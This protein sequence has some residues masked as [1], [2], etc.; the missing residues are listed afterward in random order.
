MKQTR[1]LLVAVLLVATAT[2]YAQVAINTD[3]STP[4]P[5]AM[6]EV[7]STSA[8]FLLP[9][10]TEA[11]RNAI[12]NP[13][14]GLIVYCSDCGELQIYIDNSWR[15]IL[16]GLPA[17]NVP[18]V[19][20]SITGKV[21]MDRNLGATQVATSST[22]AAAYGD[23][24]QWGRLADGHE[25]RLSSNTTVLSEGDEP[26]HGDFIV[27]ADFPRDWRDPQNTSLWVGVTGTN[28]PCPIGFRIPTQTEWEDER[29]SWATDDADGAFGSPLK[30][31]LSG[32]RGNSNG[33]V[34]GEALFG[35]YWTTYVEFEK[36]L[37]F[38]YDNSSGSPGFY[39]GYRA[40]GLSVRCI[41]D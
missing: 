25:S 10:M 3:G 22:D 28:N 29:Q 1:M 9:R 14:D 38:T 30:L 41:K 26:G 12:A 20:N 34:G 19:T 33:V 35:Y 32:Y 6:L 24:Y 11:Q 5:S 15:N 17:T 39:N 16:G 40:Y 4:D 13:V 31:T 27:S 7:K 23:L 36:S 18:T 2:S 37:Y 21:W 8:G